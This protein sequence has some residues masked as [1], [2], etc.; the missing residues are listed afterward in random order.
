M[1][2]FVLRKYIGDDKEQVLDL[3]GKN[4]WYFP[5]EERLAYFNWKYEQ[6][7]Y[8]ESPLGFVCVDGDKIIAFRGYMLQPICIND[9]IYYNAA[10]ADTVTDAN[11]RRMGLFSRITKYSIEELEKEPRIVVSTNSSSG[12]PT[13]NGYLKLGWIPLTERKHLFSF[14]WRSLFPKKSLKSEYR[15]STGSYSLLLSTECRAAEMSVLAKGKI[16]KELISIHTDEEYIDWR[17]ANPHSEFFFIY[18]YEKGKLSAYVVVKRIANRKYDIV[19]FH[20]ERSRQ[21]RKLISYL[22]RWL[23]PLYILDWTVN[24]NDAINKSPYIYK[25]VNLNIILKRIAKFNV[26]PFLI[27]TTKV[28]QQDENW[29]VE[30]VDMRAK[31]NWCLH[32]MVADEI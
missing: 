15:K 19:D 4:L 28:S 31:Q 13:L 23:H 1:C 21:L 29:I 25:F 16:P 20:Y 30:N 5:Y 32:K 9:K 17:F 18:Y 11:Y 3:L 14:S 22:H 24:R 6:N 8:T 26:P 10:L 2:E 7:P 12:G 27:R